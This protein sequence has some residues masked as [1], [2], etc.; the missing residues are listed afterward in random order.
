MLLINFRF[1]IFMILIKRKRGRER[2]IYREIQ[3]ERER[4]RKERK[5]RRKEGIGWGRREGGKY[6]II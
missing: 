1:E 6:L 4:L 3:R 5:E 2:D